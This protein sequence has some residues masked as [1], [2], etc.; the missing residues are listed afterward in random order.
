MSINFSENVIFVTVRKAKRN[1]VITVLE[2]VP[3]DRM[4][5]ML[6]VCKE[7]FGCS[8][9]VL[10]ENGKESIA[11]QGDQKFKIEKAKG[12]IFSGFEIRMDKLSENK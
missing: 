10:V 7:K 3:K 5:D 11:L 2:N 4:K 9:H 12:T 8:G 6:G 1:S